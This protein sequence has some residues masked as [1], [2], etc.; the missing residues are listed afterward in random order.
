MC[1]GLGEIV[2]CIAVV[3]TVKGLVSVLCGIGGLKRR[4]FIC[5][6]KPLGGYGI[7]AAVCI[8]GD[9]VI[10]A[11]DRTGAR[12]STIVNAAADG[13]AAA[14]GAAVPDLAVESGAAAVRGGVLFQLLF[15]LHPDNVLGLC[16]VHSKLVFGKVFNPVGA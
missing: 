3:P 5:I 6:E 4:C 9:G 8:K 1:D 12:N 13:A 10:C 14:A 2:L 7:T 11:A 16:L 15:Y